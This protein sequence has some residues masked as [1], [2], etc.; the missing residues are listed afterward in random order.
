MGRRPARP[1]LRVAGAA[2]FLLAACSASPMAGVDGPV[3][4]YTDRSGSG[5]GMD[6]EITGILELA[7]DCLYVASSDVQERYPVL[8][9]Y[10]TRW[11]ADATAV[12]T[13]A[14]AAMPVGTEIWGGG[15]YLRLEDVARSGGAAA[16]DLAARCLDNTYGEIAV[17]NNQSDAIGPAS[18]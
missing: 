10:G 9:P 17:V 5:G 3:M 12:V 15:G 14:G 1:R 7:G 13:P 8:W 4:R 11:D 18:P 2:V 6:T 16:A